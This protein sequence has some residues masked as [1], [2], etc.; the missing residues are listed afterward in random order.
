MKNLLAGIR[1][2]LWE[3]EPFVV[4]FAVMLHM[5]VM[6]VLIIVGLIKIISLM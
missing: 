5:V 6:T 1:R 3:I 4:I 2:T